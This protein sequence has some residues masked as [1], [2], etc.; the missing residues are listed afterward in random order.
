MNP[1]FNQ[2]NNSQ[3]PR[4]NGSSP[5]E[6]LGQILDAGTN[7]ESLLQTLISRNPQAN[8]IISQM[9]QS[10]MSPRDFVMQYARQNNINLQPILQMMGKRGIKL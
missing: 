6:V 10:G 8:S 9:K 2:N 3:T 1:I 7:P 4:Q 5:M